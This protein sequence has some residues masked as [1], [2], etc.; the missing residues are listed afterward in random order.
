MDHNDR[1][2]YADRITREDG[3]DIS[4][5]TPGGF[6]P[7]DEVTGRIPAARDEIFD[8]EGNPS[9]DPLEDAD[10]AWTPDSFSESGS[11]WDGDPSV[12]TGDTWA[13]DTSGEADGADSVADTDRKQCPATGDQ[14]LEGTQSQDEINRKLVRRVQEG[15]RRAEGE[16]CRENKRLVRYFAER[17]YRNSGGR[18]ELDDLEQEGFMGLLEAAKKFDFSKGVRFSTYAA[19]WIR[20]EISRFIKN[21]GSA[22]R[23][24]IRRL[25][26]ISHVMQ[27]V[28]EYSDEENQDERIR[29]AA[30]KLGMKPADVERDLNMYQAYYQMSSLDKKIGEDEDTSVG[31]MQAEDD[32]RSAEDYVEDEDTRNRLQAAID[33]LPERE[34]NIVELRYGLKD[35][36]SRS[37][38]EIGDM[39]GLTR[40]RIRLIIN[41]SLKKL[42][43]N[44]NL[45]GM[46]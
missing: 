15:D 44:E 23:I 27:A 28:N 9:P 2:D 17:G 46:E 7:D 39:Y 29:K 12:G 1:R 18:L 16:L 41:R 26:E 13:P 24:P 14:L 36:R 19:Y 22:I 34:K 10:D 4:F 21:N 32:G 40:E 11:E 43:A 42:R 3:S 30:K 20:L 38:E 31:D 33:S 35:G 25:N 5:D 6:R 45:R 8:E 37:L